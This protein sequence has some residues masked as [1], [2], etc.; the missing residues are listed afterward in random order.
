[1]S[2]ENNAFLV[3]RLH[4]V[5]SGNSGKLMAVLNEYHEICT[6]LTAAGQ[7]TGAVRVAMQYILGISV[8]LIKSTDE[9]V[10]KFELQLETDT[11]L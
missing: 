5:Y 7:D 2:L 11:L 10:R 3:E 8:T 1:M 6:L 4:R 9:A